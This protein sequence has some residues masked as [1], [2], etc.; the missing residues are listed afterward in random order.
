M[1]MSGLLVRFTPDFEILP[2]TS[3]TSSAA[4]N[5]NPFKFHDL[6]PP[7]SAGD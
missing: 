1:I 4:Q 6:A 5:P 3:A 2:G 7:S